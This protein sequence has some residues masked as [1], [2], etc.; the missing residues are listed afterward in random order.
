MIQSDTFLHERD[1]SNPI[2]ACLNVTP[3][4]SDLIKSELNA[5]ALFLE[6]KN[7]LSGSNS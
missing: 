3:Q 1:F 2:A 7:N 5:D 4:I 6:A